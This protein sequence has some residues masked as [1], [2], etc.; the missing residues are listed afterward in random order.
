MS[1][2][3][4]DTNADGNAPQTPQPSVSTIA[5][6]ADDARN[7]RATLTPNAPLGWSAHADA[8]ATLDAINTR[9][10]S[11]KL[12]DDG[13]GGG[14][15][16]GNNDECRPALTV[17]DM[18]ETLNN[19]DV[20]HND[21]DT[22]AQHGVRTPPAQMRVDDGDSGSAS[23]RGEALGQ[24]QR[25]RAGSTSSAGSVVENVTPDMEDRADAVH[26]QAYEWLMQAGLEDLCHM[27]DGTRL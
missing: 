14:G 12:D 10:S 24:G 23:G 22:S 21:D 5:T 16:G 19:I 9:I 25:R 1:L 18:T 20:K 6:T 11:D 8:Q 17:T 3:D 7:R 27:H 13:A 4:A 15:K 26:K 2:S